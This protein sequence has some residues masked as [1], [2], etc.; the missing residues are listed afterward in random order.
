MQIIDGKDLIV[1]RAASHIAK[2]LLNG[3]QIQLVNSEKMIMIGDKNFIIEKYQQRRRIQNKGKPEFSPHWPKLPNL[4]VRK[5]IRGMLPWKRMRGKE[6]FRRLKVFIGMPQDTKEAV[7]LDH[8][9]FNKNARFITIYQLCKYLGF[10][11]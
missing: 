8:A 5:I 3:E 11:G 7:S 10:N 6:A 4:L 9:K 2:M 1:G